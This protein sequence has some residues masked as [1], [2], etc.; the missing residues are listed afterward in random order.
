MI[1]DSIL[2]DNLILSYK[3]VDVKW[4]ILRNIR[5]VLDILRRCKML[6]KQKSLTVCPF[7]IESAGVR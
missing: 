5:K 3:K 7:S 2:Y 1:L 6:E 4:I